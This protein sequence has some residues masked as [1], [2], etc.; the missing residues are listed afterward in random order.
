MPSQLSDAKRRIV[1]RLKRVESA[2]APEL[3]A[4]FGLTDTAVR[5]HLEGLEALAAPAQL[6]ER[7]PSPDDETEADDPAQRE[8]ARREERGEGPAV[9]D[10]EVAAPRDPGKQDEA[11]DPGHRQQRHQQQRMGEPCAVADRP[12]CGPRRG[13]GE[14]APGQLHGRRA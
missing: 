13:G 14:D 8:H 1:E 2:T 6:G 12:A 7:D 5:Q 10:A 9:D 4:S 3:A 11:D